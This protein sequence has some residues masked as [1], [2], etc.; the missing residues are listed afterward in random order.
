MPPTRRTQR[1]HATANDQVNAIPAD[2][3][4]SGLYL[5]DLRAMC[6]RLRLSATGNRAAL[7]K[8]LEEA[9]QNSANV[10][11]SNANQNGGDDLVDGD[12]RLQQQFD[13]LKQQ[14]QALLDR[15][16]SNEQLLSPGQ[17]TQV[18][19]L[20]QSSMNEAIEKTATAAAQAAVNAFR[21]PSP[22][23]AIQ[24]NAASADVTVT[25]QSGEEQ[26]PN[27]STSTTDSVH[28]LPAKLAKEILTGEFMELSKLL[29][30]NYNSLK[31]LHDEPLTLT[32][33][34][35]VIRVNKTRATSITDIE[36]WT[37]AFTAYMSVIINKFPSRSAELLEYLS[38]I[39]YAAKY[40]KGL[41]WCVYDIK[42]RQK[43][44]SNK[45]LVWSAIDSQLWL[46]TFTVAP[47]LMKEEIGV[48]QSGPSQERHSTKGGNV[49]TCHNFN[50]GFTCS[51]NPCPYLH[52]C[53]RPGCGGDHIGVNCP[54]LSGA[55]KAPPPR[56][57]KSHP[58]HHS[59]R[60]RDR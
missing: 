3:D 60:H 2:L 17:L 33:A 10:A 46:K 36:E 21:G 52:K 8:R 44:A 19:S 4:L 22:P 39:R 30:Q 27:P 13:S 51:R 48:F 32:L 47:S 45:S 56:A 14:V 12:H 54:S 50:K 1:R 57:D 53:N 29:P 40:H 16:P 55:S 42:F 15:E 20:I 25:P 28:E 35:S 18:Q 43:A 41:G 58:Q 31:P 37:T 24:T 7:V 5:K 9:R 23:A 6:G 59:A 49:G 11:T 38:L 26:G 34:N